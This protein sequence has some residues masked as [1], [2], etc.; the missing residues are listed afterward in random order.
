MPGPKPLTTCR[1]CGAPRD[2]ACRMA[3]CT[4][5]AQAWKR[6]QNAKHRRG[7]TKRARMEA[8]YART[9]RLVNERRA[10]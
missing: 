9:I 8:A 6:A 4:T 3:F 2:P 5:H 1:V 7:G 10:S